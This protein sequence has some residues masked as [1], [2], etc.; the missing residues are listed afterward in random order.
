MTAIFIEL[1]SILSVYLEVLYFRS[2]N[3]KIF[4]TLIIGYTILLRLIYLGNIELLQEE[5]YYWNYS[6]HMAAGYLDHPPVI[7]LLIR[8]G[9]QLFGNNEFGVRIGAFMCWFGTSFFTYRLTRSIFNSDTAFRA[10]I[11]AASLPIFFSVALVNTPDA[12]LI[13][14]W[15]AAL[16]FFYR[17]LVLQ[18]NRAWYW[19]GISLG[20]G[21]ASKYTIVFL[22]PA[23]L[24]YMVADSSARKWFFKPQPYLAAILA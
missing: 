20:I 6:R 5:A 21:L 22:G 14:C 18:E 3:W 10:I 15:S 11:L 2:I 4:G 17:A 23:V 8:L 19:A 24:L 16:Y 7:A 9:T 13:A 12:P 1:G